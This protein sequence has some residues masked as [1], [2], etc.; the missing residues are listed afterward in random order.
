MLAEVLV[1]STYL[2]PHLYL[3]T[4]SNS[5]DTAKFVSLPCQAPFSRVE[6][7]WLTKRELGGKLLKLLHICE[8]VT[9]VLHQAIDL[10]ISE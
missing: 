3:L 7:N 8:G 4:R 6:H 10:K 5:F 9:I 1:I 2:V